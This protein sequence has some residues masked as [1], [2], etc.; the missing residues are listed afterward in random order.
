MIL[1][2]TIFADFTCPYSYVTEEALR[3]MADDRIEVRYR[4][5][6]LF[7]DPDAV[8]TVEVDDSDWQT[9]ERLADFQGLTIQPPMRAVQTRKAHELSRF[10]RDRGIEPEVRREIY[11][12]Y[13]RDGRDIGRIDVLAELVTEFDVDAEDARIALDIDRHA[14]AVLEDEE[15]ARRLRIP[16]TPTVFLGTGQRARVLA[17][18]HGPAV[19][20]TLI[21]EA[22]QQMEQATD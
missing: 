13:W 20:R 5:Y 7:P 6:E 10:G 16:G 1:P 3:G 4:A 22:I 21:D 8:G 9:I 18:A 2:V 12:A 15:V 11:Q 14:A 19:L 17:G